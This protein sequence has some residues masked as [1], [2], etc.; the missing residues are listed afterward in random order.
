MSLAMKYRPLISAIL[1]TS[2]LF[3]AGIVIPIAGQLA[4]L[5][6]PVPLVLIYQRNGKTQGFIALAISCLL[7]G[8]LGGWESA[9]ILFFT[10]GLMAIGIAEGMRRQ[11]TPEM[12]SLF[13]GLLPVVVA[14][15]AIAVYVMRSHKNPVSVVEEYLQSSMVEA[16][17]MYSQMGFSEMSTRISMV[18]GRFVHHLTRLLPGITVATSIF[19]AA[20]CYGLSRSILSRAPGTAVLPA[21]VSLAQWHAPDIWVW[22]L[23]VGL[24]LIMVPDETARYAGWNIAIIYAVIY[25][26]Q[27][28]AVVDHYLVKARIRPLMR[29]I[30]HTIILAL[31]SIVFVIA[32]GVVDIWGDVRKVRRHAPPQ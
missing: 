11:W 1:Q 30:L 3:V 14:A 6:A 26:A 9:A 28:V 2:A 23:I 12:V 18:S 20:V 27:G 13:G 24:A 21:R 10:F 15:A 8:L 29:G 32:L 17:K 7:V 31:P 4:A 16:A 19:Q 5:F 25:L 22:G